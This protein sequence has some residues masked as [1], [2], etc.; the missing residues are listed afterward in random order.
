MLDSMIFGSSGQQT[1]TAIVINIYSP[2]DKLA[3]YDARLL[4]SYSEWVVS[5][6]LY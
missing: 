5:V 3:G 1:R 4:H 2:T 6:I